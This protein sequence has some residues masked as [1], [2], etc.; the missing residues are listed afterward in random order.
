MSDQ[1]TVTRKIHFAT[2]AKG[3]RQILPGQ[4]PVR[5]LPT[6][7]IPRISRLMALAIHFDGIIRAGG[8]LDYADLASLGHVS[9]ARVTQIMNLLLLAPD[10]QEQILFLPSIA[11]GDDP[12][13]ERHLRPIVSQCDWFRQRLLWN[14]VFCKK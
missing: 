3:R 5:D 6:E 4:E 12:I 13:T 2:R 14:N 1:L 9:R 8:I 7:R 11:N 10:I